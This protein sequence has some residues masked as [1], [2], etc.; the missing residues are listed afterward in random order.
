MFLKSFIFR[1]RV[2]CAST[3]VGTASEMSG[4]RGGQKRASDLPEL[5]LQKVVNRLVGDG[6]RPDFPEKAM[7]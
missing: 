4:A 5:E 3:Y 1:A 7:F 2:C 6:N